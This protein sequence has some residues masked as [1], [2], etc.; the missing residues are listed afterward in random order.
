M[1]AVLEVSVTDPGK[2]KP[3]HTRCK[4]TTNRQTTKSEDKLVDSISQR[5]KEAVVDFHTLRSGKPPKE[6]LLGTSN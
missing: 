2:G 5:A 4:K 1:T 3:L 6:D